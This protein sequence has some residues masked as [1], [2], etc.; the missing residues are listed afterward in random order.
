MKKLLL[1]LILIAFVFSLKAQ[2]INV[3]VP[4]LTANP[5]D[6]I[7]VPVTLMS[8][9]SS[10]GTPIG[11]CDL[12]IN[13]DDEVL[14]FIGLANFYSG[15][16]AGEWVYSGNISIVAANWIDAALLTE[17]VPD[18][19][20]LFDMQFTYNGGNS[21]LVFSK[22]EF[23]DSEYSLIPTTTIDGAVNSNIVLH[24]VTFSVDMSREDVSP[25]GV[26]LAG[27]FNNWDYTVNP[28][29]NDGTGIFSA[30][31]Q[32]EENSTHTFRFVNGNDASGLEDVPA[33]C[34]VIN[35]SGEYE[36][37]LSVGS[38]PILLDSVCFSRCEICPP[39]H[40]ITFRVDMINED[41]SVNGMHL[42]GSFNNWS[43]NSTQMLL[44]GAGAVYEVT[45]QLEEGTYSEYK[46]INGNAVGDAEI[47]PSG[48]SNNGNRY[49]TVPVTNLNLDAICFSEC[50]ECGS[51]PEFF[52]LTFLVDM[53]NETVSP[54]GIHIAGSF[55]GWLPGTTEMTDEGNYIYS[56][57]LTLLE[58][59]SVEYR[60]VNGNDASGYEIVP[61]ECNTNGNRFF[62]TISA[63]TILPV[64]CFSACD[65]CQQPEIMV[66]FRVDLSGEGIVISP[67]GVHL[68]GSFQ[69]WDPDSTPMT[70]GDFNIFSATLSLPVGSYQEFR[71]VNGNSASGYE[72][73]PFDCA[74]GD[75]RYLTVPDQNIVLTEVC[76]ASCEPCPTDVALIDPAKP[77]LN[78]FPNPAKEEIN[79][80]FEVSELSSISISVFNLLGEVQTSLVEKTY[81]PGSQ[82]INIST[83][84]YLPGI[85]LVNIRNKTNGLQLREKLVI[86]K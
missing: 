4:V 82:I 32:L 5:G 23:Y 7:N 13:Y 45:L 38:E 57:S 66:T 29:T 75:H 12:N 27:S 39:L 48:C 67:D 59:S 20:V 71:F 60:F 65:T 17:A 46:F 34:G 61:A 50:V 11:A 8:G 72:I 73:V 86:V 64:V 16:P 33:G 47:V 3:S 51:L 76:F 58:G 85:Y 25:S 21:P 30:T 1:G 84:D 53:K 69:G 28:M 15:M 42:A 63:D 31:M 77:G 74:V 2:M 26:H 37:A 41:V 49:F 35:G 43:Y 55:Q 52:D 44:T 68:A 36:R 56:Y 81:M 62:N 79:I 54:E 22:N 40:A 9:A 70:E 14:T 10:S 80:S 83:M 18:G 19:T 78:I 6:V 24:D